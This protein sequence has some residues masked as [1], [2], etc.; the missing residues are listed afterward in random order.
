MAPSFQML[1]HFPGNLEIILAIC[2][3]IHDVDG[4]DAGGGGSFGRGS[5]LERQG[6]CDC[7]RMDAGFSRFFFPRAP[8]VWGVGSRRLVV[9]TDQV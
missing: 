7:E 9:F 3:A 4:A 1:S 8:M 5:R 2:R 6:V